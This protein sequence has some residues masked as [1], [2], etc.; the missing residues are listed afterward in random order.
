MGRLEKDKQGLLMS[1]LAIQN[2]N[3]LLSS[4]KQNLQQA[5]QAASEKLSNLEQL[6]DNQIEEAQAT[7]LLNTFSLHFWSEIDASDRP[8]LEAKPEDLQKWFAGTQRQPADIVAKKVDEELRSKNYFG[9]PEPHAISQKIVQKVKAGV[10]E[11]RAELTCPTIDRGEWSKAW[12]A[13]STIY[14]QSIEGCVQFHLQHTIKSE[15]WSARQASGWLNGAQGI[16]Y[17]KSFR[18]TCEVSAGY[19]QA[20]LFDERISQYDRAC[21]GR[22]IY[23]DDIAL[24]KKTELDPFPSPLPPTPDPRWYEDWYKSSMTHPR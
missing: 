11:H 14:A 19:R 20:S 9:L 22:L 13:A 17:A 24:G 15:G 21:R 10:I 16:A 23:A 5:A 3:R 8:F 7:L 4:Q 1:S 18:A 12:K 2:Q 6:T